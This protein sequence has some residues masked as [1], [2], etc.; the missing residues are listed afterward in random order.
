[1][2]VGGWGSERHDQGT[3]SFRVRFSFS[4]DGLGS[5]GRSRGQG[6]RPAERR[7]RLGDRR[8]GRDVSL[9]MGLPNAGKQRARIGCR[10]GIDVSLE[11]GVS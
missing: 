7:H 8:Q 3:A 5:A 6:G 1:M 9:G 10:L 11:L 2:G 4:D